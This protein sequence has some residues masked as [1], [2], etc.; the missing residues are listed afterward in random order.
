MKAVH[1]PQQRSRLGEADTLT[2]LDSASARL[3]KYQELPAA[4]AC[5]L[6]ATVKV[7]A[8]FFSERDNILVGLHAHADL[9]N[10][11]TLSSLYQRV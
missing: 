6:S 11:L 8:A 7:D 3:L 4:G 1:H 2:C 9:N 5:K 10:V